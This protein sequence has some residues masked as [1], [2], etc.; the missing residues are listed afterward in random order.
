MQVI[1]FVYRF[2]FSF[3]LR[4]IRVHFRVIKTATTAPTEQDRLYSPQNHRADALVLNPDP[5]TEIS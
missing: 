5:V 3:S 4:P 1:Q 2:E